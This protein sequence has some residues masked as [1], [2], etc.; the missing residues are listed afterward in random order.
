M[1]LRKPPI[2]NL[3]IRARARSTALLCALLVAH[4]VGRAGE[5]ALTPPKLLH[6][7]DAPDPRRDRARL[8]ASVELALDIDRDG[9]VTRVSITRSAAKRSTT[10]RSRPRRPSRSKLPRATAS[11]R[12][13]P[14]FS[15][16]DARVEKKWTFALWNIAVYLD[17]Q[18]V[19]NAENREGFN[20]NYDYRRRQG[21]R[22]LPSF[23]ILAFEVSYEAARTAPGRRDGIGRARPACRFYGTALPR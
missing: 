1:R 12:R 11:H 14:A 13:N 21:V 16:L 5:P 18:N 20:Y 7:V 3:R 10:Q 2:V 19:L 6:Y 8:R 9:T 4:R 17:C 15:R 22:G 23:R